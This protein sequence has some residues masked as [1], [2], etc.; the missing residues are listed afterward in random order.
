MAARLFGTDGVRGV[1]N[2]DVLS[3]E[4]ALAL[5]RASAMHA[6]ER[7]AGP[8]VIVVGRDT[9]RSGPMLE[10]AL[11]AGI[12]A[13]GGLALRAGV[14][15]T[16]GV[17]WLVREQSASLG[18]VISASH[19]PFPDNGIKLFGADGFKLGDEEEDRVEE[20]MRE[21]RARPNGAGVGDSRPLEGAAQRYASWAAGGG[22]T[23]IEVPS[24][25]VLVDCAHGAASTVAPLVFAQLG[26]EHLITAAEP[27][28]VNI[29][30][31]VG[32]THLD[33]LARGV[34]GGGFDLGIAFDGD[35]D[36]M[37]A[38]DAGGTVVDGDQIIALLARDLQIAGRLPGDKV[39]VTSM[40][41][42]GFHRAMRAL[43]IETVVTDVGDRYV[44][45]GMLEHGAVLGGEQ[46]G[47]VIALDRQTTGDGLI[48]AVLLLDALGRHHEPLAEAATIVRRF[49]QVLINVRADR[50]RL[51]DC[52]PVWEAVGRESEPLT[53]TGSG[54]I[55][56]RSSG[57]EPV[58]RVMVEHE[59]EGELHRIANALASEVERELGIA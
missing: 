33:A 5:G 2:G 9:R 18:A 45:A 46:S 37:L 53:A 31:R 28:G 44:L 57:T 48:T 21:E 1:A 54:R 24:L 17:A 38:V 35:A 32:S 47:H 59:D 39:V 51:A 4:L 25:R 10:D 6:R 41:N 34:R 11:C 30:D 29:N 16:P 19:N 40:S 22:G 36:R 15:P 14:L 49:P 3:P 55:V 7:G 8:P 26:I 58:V 52:D 27:D 56:L 20:L 12:A 13:A 50:T 23:P 43:G 42:L